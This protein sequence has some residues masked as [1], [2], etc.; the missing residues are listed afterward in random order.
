MA[1]KSFGAIV[2]ENGKLRLALLGVIDAAAEFVG[3]A[4]KVE[5]DEP[6][7]RGPIGAFSAGDDLTLTDLR[8]LA[9]EIESAKKV[10]GI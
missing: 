1:E 6:N 3:A 5:R 10:V 8:N 4:V 7:S 2:E 9:K